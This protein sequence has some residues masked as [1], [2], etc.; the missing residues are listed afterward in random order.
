M[1]Q[2]ENMF[3]LITFLLEKKHPQTVKNMVDFFGWPRSTVFNMVNT[4]VKL[5]YLSQP[6]V[7]GAYFPTQK[8][9]SL[10]QS[11]T[12]A[13]PLPTSVHELLIK[14][15]DITGE[16]ILLASPENGEAVIL[17]VVESKS[18][19]RYS[20]NSGQNIPLF[21]TAVGKVLLSMLPES[22]RK[23]WEDVQ[24]RESVLNDL[25]FLSSRGWLQSLGLYSP[26]LGGV[27]LPFRLHGRRNAIALGGPISRIENRIEELAAVMNNEIKLFLAE[28]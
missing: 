22:S 28:R 19:I 18:A 11:I 3:A 21:T 6:S 7:R 14:L 25:E 27:A 4:L 8:W 17:D 2:I 20:L 15:R 1:R 24:G 23:A 10:G 16:T 12:D 13:Y 9:L 5:G 26:E